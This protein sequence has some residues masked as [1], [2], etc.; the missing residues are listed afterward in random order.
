MDTRKYTRTEL[1]A[2]GMNTKQIEAVL[3]QQVEHE[4]EPISVVPINHDEASNITSFTDLQGYAKGTVVRFPDFAAGQPFVARVRRPSLLVLAKQGKIPNA[5][6]TT[7]GELF[8]KGSG[9]ID[10]DNVG[11]LGDMYEVC[12]I[13][14]QA[15]LISPTY[16]EIT[17][18]GVQLSDDQLMAIFSYTQTGVKALDSFR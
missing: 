3:A 7:A 10:A 17:K 9:G 16:E 2:L 14:A 15:A 13:I 12:E 5:L 6:L 18:A 1:E 8:T 11:M 4:V